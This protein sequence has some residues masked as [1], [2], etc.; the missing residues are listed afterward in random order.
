MRDDT[1]V[2]VRAL[3]CA[4]AA[5][6]LCGVTLSASLHVDGILPEP[7]R[8]IPGVPYEAD[9]PCVSRTLMTT[10]DGHSRVAVIN[11]NPD[12]RIPL[13]DPMTDGTV[14]MV[15]GGGGPFGGP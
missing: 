8:Q 7:F 13:L 1:L 12:P 14:P 15:P 6:K 10:S 9:A 2:L 3:E 11:S 4:R 5:A